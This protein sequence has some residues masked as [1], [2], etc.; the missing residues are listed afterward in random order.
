MQYSCRYL[1]AE[2]VYIGNYL[3]YSLHYTPRYFSEYITIGY[4]HRHTN[5]PIVLLL[6]LTCVILMS[7][8]IG[9]TCIHW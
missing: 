8:P 4:C 1:L 5:Q 6:C 9:L 7:L 3:A 2:H